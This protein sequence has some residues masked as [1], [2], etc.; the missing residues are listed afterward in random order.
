MTFRGKNKFKSGSLKGKTNIQTTSEQL[1]TNFKKTKNDFFDP[2]NGQIMGTKYVTS[3]DFQMYFGLKTSDIAIKVL[4]PI[5]K[6]FTP[7]A[8]YLTKQEIS[9]PSTLKGKKSPKVRPTT[10]PSVRHNKR[11]GS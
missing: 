10:N 1:Q 6:R 2:K 3:D 4:K 7:H 5:L 8:R 9:K 11:N